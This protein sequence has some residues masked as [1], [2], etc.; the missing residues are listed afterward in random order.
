MRIRKSP[1]QVSVK[2]GGASKLPRV[3][4]SER[5]L[6]SYPVSLKDEQETC[7]FAVP[8]PL[9]FLFCQASF[10]LMKT[11]QLK[12][13]LRV[14]ILKRAKN[15]SFFCRIKC[16]IKDPMHSYGKS[17]KYCTIYA[18]NQISVLLF[19][20][21]FCSFPRR[22]MRREETKRYLCILS[23]ANNEFL[24]ICYNSDWFIFNWQYWLMANVGTESFVKI[25][26]DIR[27]E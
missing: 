25:N 2:E 24:S 16:M 18:R 20:M 13:M 21:L 3:W 26:A 22:G 12:E 8:L 6:L 23:Q 11:T 19:L 4:L 15:F 10:T 14:I 5:K 27:T 17:W 7:A 1:W 9:Y